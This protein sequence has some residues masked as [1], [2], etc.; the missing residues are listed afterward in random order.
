MTVD[1][2]RL[3]FFYYGVEPPTERQS[4]R[5]L[6]VRDE[7]RRTLVDRT[8]PRPADE[9]GSV[10]VEKNGESCEQSV[11]ESTTFLTERRPFNVSRQALTTRER[12]F[13]SASRNQDCRP[14]QMTSA[15]SQSPQG[16]LGFFIAKITVKI[17]R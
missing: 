7:A 10:I 6:A 5:A 4:R 3:L 14:K 11:S 8:R 13:K 12:W 9:K 17:K 16:F 15:K 2:C 1:F